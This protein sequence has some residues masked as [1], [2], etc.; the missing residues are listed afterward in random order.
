MNSKKTLL[1]ASV[2][3]T[4]G[5]L[6]APAAM[7]FVRDAGQVNYSNTGT[8]I[9]AGAVVDLG[10]Q[11]GVALGDIAATTGTGI[12]ATRGVF[13]LTLMGTNTVTIGDQ[14][15]YDSASGYVTETA[16]GG[17]YIGTAME[18]VTTTTSTALLEVDLNAPFNANVDL[19]V[20]SA[21]ITASANALQTNSF[22][23]VFG[24]APIVVCTYTEDPGDVRP[25]FVTA[26]T[27]SNFICS[28]TADK[29]FQYVAVGTR[30]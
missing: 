17:T 3:L 7:N 30:P 5:V 18:A 27:P 13:E 24:S 8:A 28:V 25:I 2:A 1:I 4:A 15:Y 23:Q 19:L 14:L 20:Q 26:T 9:S 16:S 11:Y 22:A 21:A 10:D 12:V 6:A 29:N